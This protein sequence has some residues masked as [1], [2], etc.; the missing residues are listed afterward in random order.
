MN[1]DQI[2][3]LNAK[4]TDLDWNYARP[5]Q[6]LKCLF[7]T[8]VNPLPLPMAILLRLITVRNSSCGKVVFT[9][10]CLSTREVYT[11]PADTLL[12]GRHPLPSGHTPPR[13][14][15]RPGQTP[16]SDTPLPGRQ[17]L[18]RTVRI[19]LECILVA[20]R[21]LKVSTSATGCDTKLI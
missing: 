6:K 13:Q 18:E 1:R 3:L 10:V 8:F 20:Y 9:G 5:D 7:I 21:F 15:A 17:P 2:R 19:L 4:T 14:T 16:G 12:T 11:P